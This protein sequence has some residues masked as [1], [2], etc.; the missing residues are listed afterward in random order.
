MMM[1]YILITLYLLSRILKFWNY[2]NRSNHLPKY[3]T[4]TTLYRENHRQFV[5][6]QV[7]PKTSPIK[8]SLKI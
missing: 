6:A 5:N 4:G 7:G 3:R 1:K 8:I 2:H